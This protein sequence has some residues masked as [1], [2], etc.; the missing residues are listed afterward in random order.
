MLL[1]RKN[2]LYGNLEKT[3]T[4]N[5]YRNLYRES[6]E[7]RRLEW[8]KMEGKSWPSECKTFKVNVRFL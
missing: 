2:F 4:G 7:G 6:L 5:L 8:S 3:F 1:L